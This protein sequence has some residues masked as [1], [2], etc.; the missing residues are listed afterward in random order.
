MY[1]VSTGRAGR[2]SRFWVVGNTFR[3]PGKGDILFLKKMIF[4]A[5][6]PQ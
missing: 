5:E 4:F 1:A 3:V 6:T 2:G